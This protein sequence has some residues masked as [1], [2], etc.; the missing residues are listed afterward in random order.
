MRFGTEPKPVAKEQGTDDENKRA[1]DKAIGFK[2]NSEEE[3]Y[4][5]EHI[6]SYVKNSDVDFPN[7]K[8]G[9]SLYPVRSY[10]DDVKS[11]L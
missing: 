3:N 5:I 6:V 10:G 8:K 4:I 2:P 11:D 7:V 9:K 1:T